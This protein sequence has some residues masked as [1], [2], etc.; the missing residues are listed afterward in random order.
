MKCLE[1]GADIY[2]GVKKC[3]YCKTL[4]P[5]AVED[6]KFRDFDFKYTIT[7][8]EQV[9]KIQESAKRT[10]TKTKKKSGLEEYLAKRRAAKRAARRA[11]RRNGDGAVKPAKTKAV[12]KPET[13]IAKKADKPKTGKKFEFKKPNISFKK[14]VLKNSVFKKLDAADK[15]KMKKQ[16]LGLGAVALCL[17]LL[18]WGVVLLAGALS[19]GGDAVSSYTYTK[20]NSLYM[21]YKGKTLLISEKL[22]ADSYTRKLDEDGN[23][24]SAERAAKA[25]GIVHTTKDGKTTF[26]FED[27]DPEKNVGKLCMIQSGKAKKVEHISDAVHNSLVMTPEGDK[28]LYLKSADANGDMGVLHYWEKGFD[29]PVEISRDVDHDTFEFAGDGEYVMFLQ[30]LIRAEMRG[31]LYVKNLRNMKEEKL[32]LDTDVCK[33]FGSSQ[34]GSSHLYGKD[35][36]TEDKSFDIY[37]I[38]K[39]NRS[40]RLGERTKK[41]PVMQKKKNNIYIL[42]LA[43]DGT[44]TLYNVEVNSGKKEKI[45]SGM[46]GVLMMSKDEKT[47]I[48]DKVYSGKLADYY[49]YTR[50]KQ[51][52]KIAGNVVVDYNVVAGKPQMAATLDGRRVIYI[53][54]F[55][56]FKGGGTLT[57]CEYKNGRIVSEEKIAEDVYSCYRAEDGK[58]IFTKDY[59][60]SRKVFDVY[61]LDG[62]E[63]TLLKEEVSPEMFGVSKEG[64]TIYYVSNYNVEGAFGTLEMMDLEGNAE[65]ISADVFGFNITAQDDVLF[66]KNLNADDGSFEM[67]LVEKGR[68]DWA[69]LNTAVDEVLTY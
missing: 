15:K 26:F 42:G 18:I 3:P 1:C 25:A 29:E 6:E 50:G 56:A 48:Y 45:A 27:F 61:L 4:T 57:L 68:T 60:P 62:S 65:E 30:N 2:E 9:K 69:Q 63:M 44:N 64:D 38:N 35:Y 22:V 32:K 52:E 36:D 53:S 31:D 28:V 14:P 13:K 51:P 54:E 55:E 33:L 46:Y 66:Y 24:V 7:S 20:D 43:D 67:C 40:I 12:A 39:D 34:D 41:A 8:D 16:L 47:V 17:V 37:A 5:S 10:G 11:A 19:G 49:A 59:S 23:L 58:F 21:V